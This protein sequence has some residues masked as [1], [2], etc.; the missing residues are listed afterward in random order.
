MRQNKVHGKAGIEHNPVRIAPQD[1]KTVR[2]LDNFNCF[3]A[4]KAALPKGKASGDDDPRSLEEEVDD[5]GN[6]ESTDKHKHGPGPNRRKGRADVS[7]SNSEHD[8]REAACGRSKMPYF[9]ARKRGGGA[10]WRGDCEDRKVGGCEAA[11]E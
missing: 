6:G 8:G 1:N 10:R 3:K 2:N 5:N 9:V 7:V 11:K 4:G